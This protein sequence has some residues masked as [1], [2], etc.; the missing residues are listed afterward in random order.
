MLYSHLS[1]KSLGRNPNAEWT[2]RN[3]PQ[4]INAVHHSGLKPFR[5]HSTTEINKQKMV[6]GLSC[7]VDNSLLSMD[8]HFLSFPY[9]G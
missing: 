6:L 2:A 7:T 9:Y 4:A 1:R 5:G 8:N 3:W